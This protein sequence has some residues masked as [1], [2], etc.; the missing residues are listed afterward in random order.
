MKQ[1]DKKETKSSVVNNKFT[2]ILLL[3]KKSTLTACAPYFPVNPIS[4]LLKCFIKSPFQTRILGKVGGNITEPKST[5][6]R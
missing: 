4:I 6:S 1:F 5:Q 3:R 2:I